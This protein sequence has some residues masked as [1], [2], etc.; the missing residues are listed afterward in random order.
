MPTPDISSRLPWLN[1]ESG[2]FSM[3]SLLFL[4]FHFQVKPFETLWNRIIFINCCQLRTLTLI[5]S[6]CPVFLFPLQNQLLKR[7]VSPCSC[8]LGEFH[9]LLPNAA[10]LLS[11]IENTSKKKHRCSFEWRCL[12][13]PAIGCAPMM[14]Q[15]VVFFFSTIFTKF[16]YLPAPAS[17]ALRSLM[18]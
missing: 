6:Q 14:N 2:S 17:M 4:W 1:T 5:R 7:P 12:I 18:A 15:S 10:F 3:V 11:L 13:E 16:R 8:S 9:P